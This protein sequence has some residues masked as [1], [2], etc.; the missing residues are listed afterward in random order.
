MHSDTLPKEP[1]VRVEQTRGTSVVGLSIGDT[2]DFRVRKWL[3][4]Q[5]DD[6]KYTKDY[7][8]QAMADTSVTVWT[9]RSDHKYQ[10]QPR[11]PVGARKDGGRIVIMMRWVDATR[12][13]DVKTHFNAAANAAGEEKWMKAPNDFVCGC[14]RCERK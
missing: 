12:M 5:G 11:F 8:A 6:A 2:M 9:C 10:H 13:Y 14:G 1:G 3:S 4:G 7:V